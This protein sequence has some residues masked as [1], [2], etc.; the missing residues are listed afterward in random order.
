[1]EQESKYEGGHTCDVAGGSCAACERDGTDPDTFPTWTREQV[2]DYY[3]ELRERE[4][5]KK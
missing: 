5:G 3:A 1:M 2:G 4:G